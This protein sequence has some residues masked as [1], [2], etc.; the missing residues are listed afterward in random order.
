MDNNHAS[1]EGLMI[2]IKKEL[3]GIKKNTKKVKWNN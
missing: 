3:Q 1:K 2:E